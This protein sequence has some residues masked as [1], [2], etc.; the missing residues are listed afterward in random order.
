M[1]IKVID[2]SILVPSNANFILRSG[3]LNNFLPRES[4]IVYSLPVVLY[5]SGMTPITSYFD[6]I[7]C[8]KTK[9]V[10]CRLISDNIYILP[11]FNLI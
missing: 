2:T 9:L 1:Y 4:Q 6:M 8:D 5:E 7:K 10:F 3:R 11:L